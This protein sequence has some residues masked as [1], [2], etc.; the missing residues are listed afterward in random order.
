MFAALAEVHR[1]RV[2]ASE[3]TDR[4]SA[5]SGPPPVPHRR[6]MLLPPLPDAAL[7]GAL[8]R[9]AAGDLG[10]TRRQLEGPLWQSLGHG[11]HGWHDL[12]P[13][14]PDVRIAATLAG[15]PEG[16]VVGGWAALRLLG[17]PS[18]DGRT[19]AAGARLQPVLLHVGPDGRTRPTERVDVDRGAI[20]PGDLV[21]VG[22]V[23]VLS[24]TATCLAIARRYG[25]EEGLVAADAAVAA[26]LTDRAQLAA[27]LRYLP[28][29]A[30]GVRAAR[31]MITLVDGR[32]A[33]PPESRLRYVWVVQAE[34]PVP[35]VNVD[36]VDDLGVFVG[37]PDLLEVESATVAEYDGAQ[38]R[39]LDQHTSDNAREEGFEH[40][41][42]V[43]ARATSLDLWPRRR[44]LVTRLQ[45]AHRRGMERD[46]SRDHWR[47][48]A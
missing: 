1:R 29:R 38:H 15:Q 11:V 14:D 34:L 9:A 45:D 10:V 32:A 44:Q 46:R 23:L 37:R 17:V 6:R 31:L 19:G 7:T 18:C 41:G 3:S 47:W 33:S 5:G 26:G 20:P 28:T 2:S 43:V 24:A 13:G 39:D 12:S 4:A 30:R 40:R 8:T 27:Q 35:Q 22:G 42:L 48:I 16:T 21:Q 36:V 25:A